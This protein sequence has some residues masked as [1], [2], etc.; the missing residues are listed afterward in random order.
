MAGYPIRTVLAF[1]ACAVAV[2][3]MTAG[4][5][6]GVL[7]IPTNTPTAKP[8]A[9]SQRM[10]AAKAAAARV[11][12]DLEACES[13][14]VNGSLVNDLLLN[15]TRARSSALA[16]AQSEHAK[17][18][19]EFA[20]TALASAQ[21]YYNS[22]LVWQADEKQAKAAWS[23]GVATGQSDL[24]SFRHPERYRSLWVRAGTSLGAARALLKDGPR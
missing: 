1:G 17:V 15:S 23:T 22:C 9:E 24:N 13:A 20:K 4:C 3:A 7:P 16:F 6:G 10:R 12:A 14:V 21:D 8:A 5:S 18:L 11:L 19:P 2:V